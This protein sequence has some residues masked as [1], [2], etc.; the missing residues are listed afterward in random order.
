M[1]IYLIEGGIYGLSCTGKKCRTERGAR[2]GDRKER[3][4]ELYGPGYTPYSGSK[5][6][7]LSYYFKGQDSAL[8]FVFKDGVV[9]E[10]GFWVDYV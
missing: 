5:R 10:I 2:I 9:A 4:I 8:F 7:S 6:D 3:V 1:K